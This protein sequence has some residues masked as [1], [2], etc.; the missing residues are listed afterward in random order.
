MS[1]N[2]VRGISNKF[3]SSQ[4]NDLQHS[5]LR[6]INP[7]FGVLFDFIPMKTVQKP[8]FEL[9]VKKSER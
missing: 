1:H 6:I 8:L 4:Y 9:R 5:G 3:L 7:N 2:V